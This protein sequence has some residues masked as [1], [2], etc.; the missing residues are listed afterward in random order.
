M[1]AESAGIGAA[2]LVALAAL[3]LPG[4]AQ[5]QSVPLDTL[6]FGPAEQPVIGFR[7][8]NQERLLRET[9]RGQILLEN[10]RS[11][12]LALERENDALSELLASEERELTGLRG[13]VDPEEFRARADA[14]DRRVETIR[15]ERGRLAQDL[16][17]RYDVEAQAFFQ[18]ALPVIA[19][20]MQEQGI[21]AI[22]SPESV[23]LA[24]DWLDIT[25]MAIEVLDAATAP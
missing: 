8:L 24:A 7:I 17:R 10:L 11:A 23:I 16:A 6:A 22:L 2:A 21:V 13:S 14:F 9:R 25:D 4:V 1:R 19:E 18:S 5:Q 20:L 3:S 15:A 12:E